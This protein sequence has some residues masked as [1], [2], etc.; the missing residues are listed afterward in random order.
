MPGYN[1]S[2]RGTAR[3]VPITFL[4]CSMYCFFLSFCVLFVCKCVLYCCHRV[5]TQL[6]LTNIYMY[7]YIYIYQ[8]SYI[9][10]YMNVAIDHVLAVV[11]CYHFFYH[12]SLLPTSRIKERGLRHTPFIARFSKLTT[13][14][15][16]Y[17]SVVIPVTF[18]PCSC[19]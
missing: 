12:Q 3:T 14:F 1:S 11:S 17:K 5:S 18:Y 8:L 9:L 6:Q 19:S 7:I 10:H 16:T 2:R 15:A 13:S 4:C